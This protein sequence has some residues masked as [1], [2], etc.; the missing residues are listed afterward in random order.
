MS[1]NTV[2]YALYI[3]IGNSSAPAW[4]VRLSRRVRQRTSHVAY[5]YELPTS[6]AVTN[7]LRR[8]YELLTARAATNFLRH[9]QVVC[10]GSRVR[11]YWHPEQRWVSGKVVSLRRGAVGISSVYLKVLYEPDEGSKDEAGV[12]KVRAFGEELRYMYML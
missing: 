6:R 11:L 1:Q 5:G 9:A 4:E 12:T 3:A 8:G 10:L 7:F 2:D